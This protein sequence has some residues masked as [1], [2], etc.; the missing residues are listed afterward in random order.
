MTAVVAVAGAALGAFLVMGH[1][2]DGKPVK[3]D[4]T[5]GPVSAA[6]SFS[7]PSGLP[8]SLPSS[9]PSG[10]PSGLPT[11]LPSLPAGLPTG[12]PGF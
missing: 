8:S 7:L 12:W 2:A 11:S 4:S 6:P 3:N 10:F 1:K 9:L 5:I